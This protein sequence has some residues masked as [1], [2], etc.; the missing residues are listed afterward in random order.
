M[1][2]DSNPRPSGPKPDALPSCA[3]HRQVFFYLVYVIEGQPSGPA[4]SKSRDALQTHYS[5]T[6]IFSWYRN[7]EWE[8]CY[9][10][11]GVANETWT[12]DNRNHNPGLYQLSYSHHCKWSVKRDSN[13]RPSGPK[14]DALP[15]CA[16]HRRITSSITAEAAYNT[17]KLNLRKYY[18]GFFSVLNSF[19]HLSI[20]TKEKLTVKWSQTHL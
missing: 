2:R 10:N 9:Q 16:I 7:Q 17:R 20:K 5:S 19:A 13:P 1:K 4:Y 18:A 8:Q 12:R 11:N 3:I 14:P 6:F 15:N